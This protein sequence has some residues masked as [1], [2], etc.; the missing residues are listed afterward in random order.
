MP[1]LDVL[2]QLDSAHNY[3]NTTVVYSQKSFDQQVATRQIANGEEI[4]IGVFVTGLTTSSTDTYNFQVINDSTAALT[5]A[6]IVVAQTGAMTGATDNRI[7]AALAGFQNGFFLPIPPNS[8]KFEFIGLGMVGTNTT[9]IT[10][11][12]YLMNA[13][14]WSQYSTQPANYTP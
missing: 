7:N 11:D 2:L 3:T 9:N 12:A 4:G 10:V 6:P 5:S 8:L 14:Q 1:V 13:A